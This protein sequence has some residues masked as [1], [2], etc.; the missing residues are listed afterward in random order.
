MS[1]QQSK[2]PEHKHRKF[3]AHIWHAWTKLA[4]TLDSLPSLCPFQSSQINC[5]QPTNIKNTIEFHAEFIIFQ[6]TLVYKSAKYS[7]PSKNIAVARLAHT[8]EN[9]RDKSKV[10]V[11]IIMRT[12]DRM[13]LWWLKSNRYNVQRKTLQKHHSM[14]FYTTRAEQI[15]DFWQAVK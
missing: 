2:R 12:M 1:E 7:M 5:Q 8:Q 3:V 9:V 15:C 6:R 14:P 10:Y 11:Y 13:C 4:K